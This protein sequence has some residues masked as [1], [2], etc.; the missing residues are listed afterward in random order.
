M[1]NDELIGVEE[2]AESRLYEVSYLLIPS[3][4]EE[5]A[6]KFAEELRG[7]LTKAGATIPFEEKP[8]MI[9]LA[10][11]MA[12]SVEHKR[13]VY[14]S[15]YFGWFAFEK[16]GG[17][18]E[19]NTWLEKNSSVIR[20]LIINTIKEAYTM[21]EKRR[22]ILRPRTPAGGKEDAAPAVLP[23]TPALPVDDAELEKEIEHL[24]V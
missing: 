6:D 2:G 24:L 14:T 16:A 22:E 18:S 4:H 8:K 11:P 19:I 20:F 3:L 1:E 21:R 5:N 10:Y 7:V 13:S 9:S 15:A 17:V 23:E 12:R